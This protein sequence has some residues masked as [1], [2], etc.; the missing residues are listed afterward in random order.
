MGLIFGARKW[1]GFIVFSQWKKKTQETSPRWRAK[2]KMRIGVISPWPHSY[3]LS[4]IYA[5][6]RRNWS[7]TVKHCW[8]WQIQAMQAE[9]V[10]F[11]SSWLNMLLRSTGKIFK[12]LLIQILPTLEF[13]FNNWLHPTVQMCK[14][15]KQV[16]KFDRKFTW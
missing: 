10:I 2:E 8:T 6:E 12:F 7:K 16:V 14:G 15:M 4:S 3:L 1:L 11:F 13:F 5:T 9:L